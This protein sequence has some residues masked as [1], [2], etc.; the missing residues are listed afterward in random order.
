MNIGLISYSIAAVCFLLLGIYLIKSWRGKFEGALLIVAAISSAIWALAGAALVLEYNLYSQFLY[1]VLETSRYLVWYWFLYRLL[2]PLLAGNSSR[3]WMY[4]FPAI[5]L[6]LGVAVAAIDTYVLTTD[7][8]HDLGKNEFHLMGHLALSLLGLML[9]EQLFRNTAKERRWNVKYLYFG[10]GAIFMFDFVLYSDALLFRQLD[11]SLWD[12]RGFIHALTVPLLAV[13]ASRNPDWTLNVFISQRAV[14]HTVALVGAGIYLLFMA[15]AGYYIKVYGGSWGATAQA[16][17]VFTAII[18]L[19]I[20]LYSGQMRA[21]VRIFLNKHF[22]DY[23]YDYRD[24]WLQLS[25]TLTS[26]EIGLRE[27]AIRA[28]ADVV[29]SPEGVMW[30]RNERGDFSYAANW[31]H[32]ASVIE[33]IDSGSPLIQF[34]SERN[35]MIDIKECHE[36]PGAYEGLELPEWLGKIERAWLVVPLARE[37]GLTGLVVLGDSRAPRSL[38]WEDRD[39][40]KVLSLQVANYIS[41]IETTEALS[42]A[43]QFE[44]FNRLSSYVVHDLKNISAQLSLLTTNAELHKDNPAFIED[45]FKTVS[46]A[47][48]KMNRM[49][50]QLRKGQVETLSKTIVYVEEVL[51]KAIQ[52]R[53]VSDPIPVLGQVEGGLM[54]L[55][56]PDKLVNVL[57]HLVQNAQEASGRDGKLEISAHR[58]GDDV[59]IEVMDNGCGMS[60][61]FI[62]ERLFKPFDTTKG[63]AGMGIGVFESREF[64][65]SQGGDLKVD[66]T[67]GKGTTFKVILPV[68]TDAPAAK[69]TALNGD[70]HDRAVK[71]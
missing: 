7:Y 18:L 19:L 20:V 36:K 3:S 58:R 63:N 30:V 53:S 66:S 40:F 13:T 37:G 12:A 4:Y 50:A 29:D 23:K 65:W 49:L 46:N 11:W 45:A 15:A 70:D 67:P 24:E 1:M 44:A 28:L 59:V 22:F 60:D 2:K 21:K 17:L 56:D 42:N 55:T 8:A 27:R 6:V 32:G 14:F 34:L 9:I 51:K 47:T 26:G 68:Y 41:L 33:T 35:W 10:V 48:N 43:R 69:E 39:L 61:V 52:I 31:N 71:T 54:L 62:R 57:A 16:V 38:N 5:V 64:V 25:E